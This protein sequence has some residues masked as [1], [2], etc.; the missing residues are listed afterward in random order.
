MDHL[1]HRTFTAITRFGGT[2]LGRRA[3]VLVDSL[4]RAFQNDNSDHDTNG[5]AEPVKGWLL[6]C[7]GFRL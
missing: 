3:S 7:S 5:E 4:H 6:I 2:R 1:K